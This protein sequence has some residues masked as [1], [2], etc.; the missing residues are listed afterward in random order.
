MI[1]VYHY[2][3][4]LSVKLIHSFNKSLSSTNVLDTWLISDTYVNKLHKYSILKEIMNIGIILF[5]SRRWFFSYPGFSSGFFILLDY[6]ISCLNPFSLIS[7]KAQNG[8]SWN[9][10]CFL[11]S[12]FPNI[13][14]II[15]FIK[16]PYYDAFCSKMFVCLLVFSCLF[17]L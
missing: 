2:A 5:M 4:L 17:L 14:F 8:Y 6:K 9:L 15:F 16:H 13:I 10:L 3:I 7:L 12:M 11:K 1:T